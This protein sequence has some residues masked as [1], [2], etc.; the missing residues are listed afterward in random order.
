MP[1]ENTVNPLLINLGACLQATFHVSTTDF[2]WLCVAFQLPVGAVSLFGSSPPPLLI[3][4]KT[5]DEEVRVTWTVQYLVSRGFFLAW[6]LGFMESFGRQSPIW[7]RFFFWQVFNNYWTSLNKIWWFVSGEQINYYYLFIDLR[8]TDKS[9]YFWLSEFNNCFLIRSPSLFLNE[10][11]RE[12][13]RCAIFHARVIAKHTTQLDDTAHKQNIICRQ[14]FCR[15]RG[16]LS[17]NEKDEKLVTNDNI[18]CVPPESEIPR[19]ISY[20]GNPGWMYQKKNV[21]VKI[22]ICFSH[23]IF[24]RP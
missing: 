10:Y 13:K 7:P 5:E 14:L 1:C 9:R 11:L 21:G 12:A 15:S 16:G 4:K 18:T 19:D 20:P 6:L 17:T 3:S 2:D 22:H 8:D 24:W 23:L